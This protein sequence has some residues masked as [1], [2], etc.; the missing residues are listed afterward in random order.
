MTIKLD[1]V[2]IYAHDHNESAKQFANVMNLS[3]G[4]MTG[5]DYDF[6]IVRVNH[7]LALYFMN[8]A[9]INLEQH[10]A[11]TVDGR[12]FD[13]IIKELKKNNV[14]YGSS[15]YHRTNGSTDHDFAPR[16]LFWTNLDGC[17]FE[18]MTGEF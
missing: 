3:L 6:T 16:G 12:D 11:F 7:E 13:K 14:A 10:F 18:V 5:S 8:R 15:P 1:H 2:V 9:N 4:R 17:L